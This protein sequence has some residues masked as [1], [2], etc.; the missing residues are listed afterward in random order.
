MKELKFKMWSK[1]DKKWINGIPYFNYDEDKSYKIV[2]IDDEDGFVYDIDEVEIVEHTGCSDKNEEK[3]YNGWL[4]EGGYGKYLVQWDDKNSAYACFS[5][6]KSGFLNFSF[7]LS[8]YVKC[9]NVIGNIYEN[10]ELLLN[11]EG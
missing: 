4:L 6:D 2:E 7:L 11:N 9:L 1:N 8:T 5:V 10:P 3:V